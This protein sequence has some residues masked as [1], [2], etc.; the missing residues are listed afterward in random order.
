M[1]FAYFILTLERYLGYARLWVGECAIK[2]VSF[3]VGRPVCWLRCGG[4]VL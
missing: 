4:E 1:S 3:G 2:I